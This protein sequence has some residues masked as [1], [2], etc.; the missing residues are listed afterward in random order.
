MRICNISRI[1][2]RRRVY[3]LLVFVLILLYLSRR[4]QQT[5]PT[6]ALFD[7]DQVLQR[8]EEPPVKPKPKDILSPPK[9]IQVESKAKAPKEVLPVKKQEPETEDS[10]LENIVSKQEMYLF[11]D[12]QSEKSAT[13]DFVKMGD[14]MRVFKKLHDKLWSSKSSRVSRDA[15]AD[16][17]FLAKIDDKMFKWLKPS[18]DSTLDLRGS[19]KGDGIVICVGNHH[20][21]IALSTMHMIRK[22]HSSKLPFEIFYTGKDDLSVENRERLESVPNTRTRDITKL[23]DNDILKLSG[24][25]V[26]AF[27][28]LGSSFKNAMLIDADV[29]FLQPPDVLFESEFFKENKAVFF[30]DRSLFTQGKETL[31]WFMEF[32]PKPQSAYSSKFRIFNSETAHEQESGSCF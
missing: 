16:M 20:T 15:R 10:E 32:M 11:E 24:W 29:V 2:S 13:I 17:K 8:A 27:A 31:D 28:L 30:H 22:V 26:K 6:K 1:S 4:K 3:I 7:T 14:Q 25:A 21:D 23:F 18:F 5:Y 12:E 19:F 9:D